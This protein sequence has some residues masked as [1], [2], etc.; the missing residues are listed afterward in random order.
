MMDRK[1]SMFFWPFPLTGEN[2]NFNT[3]Y[4]NVYMRMRM[5]ANKKVLKILV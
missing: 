1:T 3:V 5:I 4:N 2:L